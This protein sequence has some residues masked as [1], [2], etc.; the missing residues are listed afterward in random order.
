[1]LYDIEV[2]SPAA[3]KKHIKN[4]GETPFIHEG[5]YV[6]K[7]KIGS[8]TEVGRGTWIVESS[9]DDYSYD[10]GDVQI[11]YS[12]IGKFCSIASHVRINPGNH[13]MHRVMQHHCT[14]RRKQF[15]FSDFDDD[16]FFNWRR[17]NKCKLGHD[18]WVGHGA[19]IMPGVSISTGAVIG[20]G[21]VVTKDIGP[22]EIAVGVPARTINKRFSDKVIE[23]LILSEWWNWDR[24]TLEERFS[25]FY[26]VDAFIEKYCQENT[27]GH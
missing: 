14:Y 8:W 11:I 6:Y 3:E 18:V 15:G 5:A 27:H 23:K 20:S 7:S 19:V 10:A 12:E 9:F 21:A 2:I 24:S 16:D 4:L 17:S 26:N 1:M 22:Y 13:P 25:D